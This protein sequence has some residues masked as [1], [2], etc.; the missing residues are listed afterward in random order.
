MKRKKPIASD[1][2]ADSDTEG[3]KGKWWRFFVRFWSIVS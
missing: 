1:S 2:E 3:Q